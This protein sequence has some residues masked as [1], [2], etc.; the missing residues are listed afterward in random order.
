MFRRLREG[1]YAEYRL[2]EAVEA[3]DLYYTRTS[4]DSTGEKQVENF[5]H[6]YRTAWEVDE[7]LKRAGLTPKGGIQIQK[8]LHETTLTQNPWLA[9]GDG[10]I[11]Q[12]ISRIPAITGYRFTD[13][14]AGYYLAIAERYKELQ[15]YP[16]PVSPVV[17]FRDR[18]LRER[19]N[20][21]AQIAVGAG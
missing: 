10:M 1:K 7:D 20:N 15:N 13:A 17:S 4:E 19:Q 11:S 16:Q 12:A 3:G 8:I 18:V 2:T 14:V 9:Y 6:I 21:S 5:Y